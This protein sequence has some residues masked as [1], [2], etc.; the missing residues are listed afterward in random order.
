MS[1]ITPEF[2]R[3]I[4][5]TDLHLHL[6][7]SIRIPTL[8]EL[9][10]ENNVPLPSYT[11]EGLKETVFKDRY[12]NLGEYLSGFQYTVAALQT[13]ESLERCAYELACDNFA[14]GVR[15]IEVRF[16]PQL[17]CRPGLDMKMVLECV[18]RGLARAKSEFNRFPAIES[19]EEPPFAYGIIVCAMRMFTGK[20]SEYFRRFTGMHSHSP[21]HRLHALASMALAEAVVEI[22]RESDLPIVGFDLAGQEDGFPAGDHVEAYKY[23]HLH[24]LKKTVLAGEAYGP[25][26]IFQAIT[27]LHADRI[28]HCYHLFSKE[29]I[30]DKRIED[31][32][33]Y[34]KQLAQYIAD[35]RI[36]L[37]VCLTSNVQTMPELRSIADHQFRA[38]LDAKLSV[39]LCTD[40]RTV[41]NTTMCHE[42]EQAVEHFS[43]SPKELRNIVIYGFKRSFFP[44]SYKSKRAYVR[45]IIDYYEKIEKKYGFERN[46]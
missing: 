24:F 22:Q 34:I 19:G 41:S 7:G 38:M 12:A 42:I 6:D 9:A 44:E 43:L 20:F 5:K 8:I 1:V 31:K 39:S 29:H 28:G 30:K 35:R 13:D 14:E 15:Y 23:V 17:H 46:E 16:A 45:G 36:T 32:E 33:R 21:P 27:E 40:N 18:N 3:D 26:S 2:I 4:P 10:K 37:E 11:E 25:E